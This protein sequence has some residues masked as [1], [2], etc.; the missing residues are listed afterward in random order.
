VGCAGPTGSIYSGS[1]SHPTGFE[2][3]AAN[4]LVPDTTGHLWGSCRVHTSAGW[5]CFAACLIFYISLDG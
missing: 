2:G 3:F 5:C 4:I 1:T